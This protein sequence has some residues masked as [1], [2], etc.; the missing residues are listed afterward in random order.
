MN[1]AASPHTFMEAARQFQA[2]CIVAR[3]PRKTAQEYLIHAQAAFW[4]SRQ[5]WD[6]DPDPETGGAVNVYFAE[7]VEGIAR[8][9]SDIIWKPRI[10]RWL[11]VRKFNKLL[12]TSKSKASSESLEMLKRSRERRT[13]F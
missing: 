8:A 5:S 9:N 11:A 10:L 1:D 2:A 13:V 6:E 3:L 4:L 12:D 7:I